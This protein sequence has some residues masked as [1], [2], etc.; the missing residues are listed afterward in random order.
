MYRAL[1]ETIPEH[2]L[3]LEQ[4]AYLIFQV[5]CLPGLWINAGFSFPRLFL[6]HVE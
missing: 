6:Y 2:G 4:V 3:A 1:Q 5:P